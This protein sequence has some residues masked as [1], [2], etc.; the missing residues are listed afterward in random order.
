MVF[1]V[2]YTFPPQMP[3]LYPKSKTLQARIRAPL[4]VSIQELE[5]E[6]IAHRV[7]WLG[8]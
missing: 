7:A 8:F 6:I 2:L 1:L 5:I 4:L 3:K